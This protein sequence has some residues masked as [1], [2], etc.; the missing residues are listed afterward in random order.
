MRILRSL[1]RQF[2]RQMLGQVARRVSETGG[3]EL[4]L[5]DVLRIGDCLRVA[6]VSRSGGT[7]GVCV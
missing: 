2:L 5:R 6:S 1:L 7:R 4:N 3:R